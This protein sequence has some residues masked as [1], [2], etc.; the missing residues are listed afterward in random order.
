M[1]P[2][3][4]EFTI[5]TTDSSLDGDIMSITLTGYLAGKSAYSEFQVILSNHCIISYML[6]STSDTTNFT[7]PPLEYVVA[8]EPIYVTFNDFDKFFSCSP[9]PV[10]YVI[11]VEGGATTP[12][13]LSLDISL[14]PYNLTIY[15]TSNAYARSK[16]YDV[17]IRAIAEN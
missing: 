11:E 16:P 4:R 7:L 1:D 14:V 9:S 8:S 6:P 17:M 12:P 10:T 2:I 13:Y 15:T 5:A 3:N